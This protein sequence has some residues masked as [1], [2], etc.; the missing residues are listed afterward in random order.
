MRSIIIVLTKAT[1]QTLLTYVCDLTILL[2][3]FSGP[4]HLNLVQ[5]EMF[6]LISKMFD[7]W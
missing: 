2:K 1:E 7:G 4:D 5:K 6:G 3:H